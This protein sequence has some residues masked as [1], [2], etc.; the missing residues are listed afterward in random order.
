MILKTWYSI[1]EL[2]PVKNNL[3]QHARTWSSNQGLELATNN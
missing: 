2:D 3:I 1:Q